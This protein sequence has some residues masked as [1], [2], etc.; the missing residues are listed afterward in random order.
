VTEGIGVLIF[1]LTEEGARANTFIEEFEGF[2]HVVDLG[3]G[4]C[5]ERGDRR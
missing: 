3:C 4:V 5:E 1:F 2:I